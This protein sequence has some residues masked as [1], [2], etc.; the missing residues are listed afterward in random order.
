MKTFCTLRE[1]ATNV[2]NFEKKKML[3][4]TK[5]EQK[6]HEDAT[7]YYI[8]GKRLPKM[9]AKDKNHGKVRDHFLST[10]KN[11]GAAHRICNLRFNVP[12]EIP[13]VFCNGS[14]YD[15]YLTI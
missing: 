12:N 2:I 14:N 15:Y 5:K 4:L 6:L 11:R 7:A 8:C 13:V 3:T 1:H 9:F 10:G